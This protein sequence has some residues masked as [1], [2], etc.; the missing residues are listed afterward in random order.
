MDRETIKKEL[1]GII[2]PYVHDKELLNSVTEQSDLITDLQINSA[3]IVDIV[4]DIEEK[5]DITIDDDAI[6][7]MNTV[8]E[9]V[10][11]IQKK[12]EAA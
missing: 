4:L 3:H 8:G 6:G 12:L 5:Y 7:Q 11:I 2:N 10:S 1:L 9:S